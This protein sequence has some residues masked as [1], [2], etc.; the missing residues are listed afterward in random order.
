MASSSR[1]HSF[2]ARSNAVFVQGQGEAASA[3]ISIV[4]VRGSVW[5]EGNRLWFIGPAQFDEKAEQHIQKILLP[6]ADEILGNLGIPKL[7]F[8]IS[9]VNPGAASLYDLGTKISGFSSD[10]P[11]VVLFLAAGLKLNLPDDLVITGHIAS[12]DGDIGMVRGIPAKVSAAVTAKMSRFIYP[13][14]NQDSS[15]DI[16]TPHEKRRVEDAIIQ[17]KKH[18][19]VA[20]VLN[21]I[22]LVRSVFSDE[23]IV[24]ASLNFRF[25][26]G[27]PPVQNERSP[28]SKVSEF[29][30]AENSAR[31]WKVLEHQLVEGRSQDAKRLLTA[32]VDYFLHQKRYPSK[33]GNRLYGLLL[34]LPPEIRRLKIKFPLTST[35]KIF[36]LCQFVRTIDHEDAQYLLLAASGKANASPIAGSDFKAFGKSA[37]NGKAKLQ[38]L[39]T[40]ANRIRSDIAKKFDSARA[41][42]RIDSVIAEDSEKAMDAATAF[43]I[44]IQRHY[45]EMLESPDSMFSQAACCEVLESAFAREGG[46]KAALAE[47]RDAPR[48]GLRYVFDLITEKLK[49]EEQEKQLRLLFKT[50]LDPLDRQKRLVVTKALIEHLRDH[51]PPEI[52]SQ[53]PEKF[54]ESCEILARNLLESMEKLKRAFIAI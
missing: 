13:T 35:G 8:Y 52:V 18:I 37:N 14:M 31:F 48:G 51:L 45:G 25:F 34:S 46:L 3:I 12:L 50:V 43:F 41:A 4:A 22:D 10:A 6:I 16:F 2:T 27:I 19:K 11:L 15:I 23:Q 38:F 5:N 53:P 40:E 7:R 36:K 44:H 28:V 9:I 49:R 20:P 1:N 21:I 33:L 29:L 54:V 26:E 42:Y 30:L 39:I 47:A 32:Y 24:I 17:A